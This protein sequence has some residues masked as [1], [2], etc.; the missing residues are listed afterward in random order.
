MITPRKL[1]LATVPIGFI[2]L[3]LIITVPAFGQVANFYVTVPGNGGGTGLSAANAMSLAT[4]SGNNSL[5]G[6]GANQVGPGTVVHINAQNSG[7]GTAVFGNSASFLN[8]VCGGSAG[9]RVTYQFQNGDTFRVNYCNNCINAGN[10]SHVLFDGGGTGQSGY[11]LG[12]PSGMNIQGW[13]NGSSGGACPG[14]SCASQAA[15]N[16]FNFSCATDCEF[17]NF[18]VSDMY[19]AVVPGDSNG[20]TST[21]SCF[22]VNGGSHVFIHDNYAHDCGNFAYDSWNNGDTDVEIYNN[23][24]S[25]MGWGIG[26]SGGGGSMTQFMVYN[27]HFYEFTRWQNTP[28][29]QNGIHCFDNSGGGIQSLYFYNNLMDGGMGS[30]GWTAWIYLEANGPGGN[31]NGGTGVAYLFNNILY[32]NPCCVNGNGMMNYFSGPGGLVANNFFYGQY[33]GGPCLG[34][35]GTNQTIVNNVFENCGQAMTAAAFG[36][37]PTPSW[38]TLDYNIYANDG[39]SGNQVWQV[40]SIGEST[41]ASWQSACNCDAHSQAQL[42][43]LL[44][45]ITSE[46]VASAGY[47]GIGQ[48]TNLTSTSTGLL[49]ALG[50][51]SGAGDSHTPVQRPGGTCSTLGSSS[52]WD[53]GGYQH[54]SGAAPPSPP[55]GLAA[56]VQ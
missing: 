12:N 38:T 51:D 18:Q 23:F 21:G 52:C 10:I 4:F 32:A 46:G 11:A 36:G 20:N 1:I 43:S 44:S 22:S 14:G 49:A 56:I 25:Q 27:N 40:N 26:C 45:N 30:G 35:S 29:H 48:G 19:D 54:G 16:A 24:M 50:Y 2:L 17:R 34:W 9:A 5:C 33:G 53:V 28:T 55:S 7:T 31:W 39:G 37:N 13:L 3:L 41:L 8:A 47:I 15:S 6:T 42:G